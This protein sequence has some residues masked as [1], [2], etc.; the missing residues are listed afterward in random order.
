M[1]PSI[2]PV[3]SDFNAR[4][5]PAQLNELDQL[6]SADPDRFWLDQAGRLT[7]NKFPTKA[8]D[9]S[10]DEDDFHKTYLVERLSGVGVNR[11][12]AGTFLPASL[13]GSGR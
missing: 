6:A 9:W 1:S 4:I 2:H 7:W 12:G 3:P 13:P 11:K 10:F 8:G 5:G